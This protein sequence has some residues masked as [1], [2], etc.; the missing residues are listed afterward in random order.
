MTQFALLWRLVRRRPWL[1]A[2]DA[3]V[4]ILFLAGGVVPGLVARTFFDT[5]T[6]KSQLGVGPY[7]VIALVVIVTLVHVTLAIAW[8]AIDNIFRI[9]VNALIRANIFEYILRRP[10]ARALPYSTGE[11]IGRYR[12]DVIEISNFL[13]K[14][15]VLKALGYVFFAIAAFTIMLRIDATITLVVFVPSI[16]VIAMSYAAGSSIKRYRNASRQAAADVTGALG[17][18]FG[19]VQVVKVANAE[20]HVIRHFDVLNK[21]RRVAALQ[22]KV[23]ESIL[24]SLLLSVVGIG[25]GVIMLIAAQSMRA[26]TFTV[27]DLAFFVHNLGEVGIGVTTIGAL[28]AQYR[29]VGVAFARLGAM[30]QGAKPET[31]CKPGPV[32]LRGTLP[33]VPYTPKTEADRLM[34]LEAAGLTYKYPES[35][36][37]VQGVML[38]I[39]RGSFTVI[40]G[41]VGSGKTTL[42]RVLLG[43]L[44]GDSGAIWWNDRPVDNP[45][46]FFVPPR[47][48]Y[49]PQV[50]RLFS[51]TL[52]ENILLGLPEDRADLPRAIRMAV[53]EHDLADIHQGLDTHIGPRGVKLSGGQIQR[54]AGARM[55]V[56]DPE[57]LVFD[58][59]SSAL[60]VETER[61]LW[62]RL[63]DRPDA[64]CLVVS[65]RRAALQRADHIIVL[66]DGV[67]EAEGTLARLLD[68][69]AEMRLLWHGEVDGD[70]GSGQ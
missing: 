29:Q 67:V 3:I 35:G 2:L 23:F 34:T 63:F 39:K 47:C 6:G 53:L 43:L 56:R 11:A 20:E 7:A 1:Y 70:S 58:D 21:R 64:T 44:P 31:L 5:L 69:C 27:G 12:D 36:R 30:L 4:G 66:R 65:H 57:L 22:D 15:G 10:G 28:L 17:E 26:G 9:S 33:E 68:E 25:T 49:T 48:A 60:D 37:G 54:V 61:L 19:G 52:K 13:S 18:M 51:Q 45:A 40:T 41:R 16:C 32:Y 46:T 50:P 42:L 38:R 55:F 62:E 14:R 24:R 8:M 59:L